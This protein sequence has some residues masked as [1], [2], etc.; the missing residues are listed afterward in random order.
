VNADPLDGGATVTTFEATID[1]S[2]AEEI[3]L[4]TATEDWAGLYE[5]VWELNHRFPASTLSEKYRAAS[6]ALSSL[7]AQ[8]LVEFVRE[9]LDDPT[10]AR[11]AV[12]EPVAKLLANPVSWY[13]EYQRHQVQFVATDAGRRANLSDRGAAV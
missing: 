4:S 2:R 8:G 3:L 13:P 6:A 12:A 7:Y 1:D 11:E 5:A 9:Q 10:Q